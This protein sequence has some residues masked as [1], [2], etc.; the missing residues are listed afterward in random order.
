MPNPSKKRPPAVDGDSESAGP[1]KKVKQSDPES[2]SSTSVG[3]N[4]ATS[5]GADDNDY[6]E[7]RCPEIRSCDREGTYSFGIG[8]SELPNPSLLRHS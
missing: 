5:R 2:A 6:W 4:A 3:A 1:A 8:R 7:V